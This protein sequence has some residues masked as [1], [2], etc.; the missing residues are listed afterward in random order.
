L[1]RLVVDANIV[2]RVLTEDPP[3]LAERATALL[4]EAA[5]RGVALVLAPLTVAE[6]VYVL[7][8]YYGWPQREIADRLLELVE[9]EIF[10]IGE[11]SAIARALTWYGARAGLG[12]ADAYLAGLV[13][14]G[15]YDA[16]ATFDEDLGRLTK[17][18]VIRSADA[19]PLL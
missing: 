10:E 5:A 3:E 6:I 18:P 8:K 4:N 1:S 17:V 19:L 12:F 15:A 13:A 9:S 16:V 2:L 14:E 11:R 7:K